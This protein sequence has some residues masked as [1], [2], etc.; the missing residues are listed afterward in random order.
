MLPVI[1]DIFIHI[2]ALLY[3][4]RE[5]SVK[6][7]ANA[8]YIL[9]YGVRHQFKDVRANSNVSNAMWGEA[10]VLFAHI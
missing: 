7:K 8:V 3:I 5:Y 9:R 6:V 2:G 1:V 4:L 10:T